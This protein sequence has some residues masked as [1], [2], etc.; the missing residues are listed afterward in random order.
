MAYTAS[1]APVKVLQESA[2][3]PLH[4]RPRTLRPLRHSLSGPTAAESPAP[5]VSADQEAGHDGAPRPL[6]S[7]HAHRSH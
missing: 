3:V 1:F 2:N 7:A 6:R 5:Q 4:E